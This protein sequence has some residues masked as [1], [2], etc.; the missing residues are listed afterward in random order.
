VGGDD[1]AGVAAGGVD[2]GADGVV[3]VVLG[4]EEEDGAG[5]GGLAA[6]EGLT[7]RDAGGEIAEEG[8]FAET[9]VA[10]EVGELPR[11]EAAGGEPVDGLGGDAVEG[12][13]VRE[14]VAAGSGHGAS[15]WVYRARFWNVV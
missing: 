12:D 7:A 4:G 11:G 14:G 1:A 3:E 8:R 6:G 2:A 13:D 10:V 5:W 15:G 9:G